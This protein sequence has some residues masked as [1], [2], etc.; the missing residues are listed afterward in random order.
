MNEAPQR[1]VKGFSFVS[2]FILISFPTSSF[3]LY[4]PHAAGIWFISSPSQIKSSAMAYIRVR[5]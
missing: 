3:D 1:Q 4:L 5:L 2:A